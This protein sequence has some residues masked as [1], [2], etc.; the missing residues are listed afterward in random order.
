MDLSPAQQ[1][2]RARERFELDDYYGALYLLHELIESGKA[3]ADAHHVLGLS[4]YMVNRPEEAL[5]SLDRAV[6][7]NPR[8]VEANIHRGI[9]LAEMGRGEEAE[10][11]FAAARESGAEDRGGVAAH[12][13][14][15]LANLHAEIGE[16]YAEA[17]QLGLAI[18][19]YERALELG[20][21]FHDLRYR[22]GRLLLDARRTLEAREQLEQVVEA[23]PGAVDAHAAYGLACYLS[24][25]AATARRVWVGIQE[26]HPHDVRVK[27]YLAML[28]RAAG[29]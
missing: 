18:Q 15:K 7:L 29:Q 27:A 19:Q 14:A 8:Y 11:S 21:T 6:E 10:A 16:A 24:G 4:Y 23:R 26:H 13:A 1:L 9:L 20:P 17:G 25:D 22:L 12:Y 5:A 2:E 3:F 28:A